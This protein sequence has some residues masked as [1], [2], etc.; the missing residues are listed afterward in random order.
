MTIR[1][2][3]CDFHPL[4]NA[5]FARVI[6]VHV[7]KSETSVYQQVTLIHYTKKKDITLHVLLTLTYLEGPVLPT[8]YLG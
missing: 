3:F 4:T 5:W 8:K 7:V 2:A 6:L 1:K